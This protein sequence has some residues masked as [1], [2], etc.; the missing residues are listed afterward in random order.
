MSRPARNLEP[1]GSKANRPEI[2]RR[3]P[4]LP[5]LPLLEQ[6]LAR[7]PGLIRF[8]EQIEERLNDGTLSADDLIHLVKRW[9][10]KLPPRR[11]VVVVLRRIE[12][13]ELPLDVP[14]APPRRHRGRK[15]WS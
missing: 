12:Q 2:G 10:E 14:P 13:S 4:G 3:F 15:R 9:S 8:I 6:W 11:G 1:S 5:A 7:Q